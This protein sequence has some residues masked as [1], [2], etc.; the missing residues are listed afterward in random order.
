[1]WG[2]FTCYRTRMGGDGMGMTCH[3][4]SLIG[5][6]NK[7]NPPKACIT[8]RVSFV[9]NGY[10]TMAMQEQMMRRDAIENRGDWN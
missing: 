7:D 6:Q 3:G 1:M 4:C 10:K 5:C 8:P 2:L 9:Q